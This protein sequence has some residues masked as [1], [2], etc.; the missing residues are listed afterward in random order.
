V[1]GQGEFNCA[2]LARRIDLAGRVTMVLKPGKPPRLRLIGIDRFGLV[3]ASAGMRDMVDAAPQRPA[4]PGIY[5]IKRQGR[6]DGNGRVQPRRRLP[7]LEADGGDRLAGTAGFR[8]RHPPAVTGD[9]VTA[10]D[11][12][13]RL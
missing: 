5:E 7:G 10:L 8:H 11:K 2:F 3:A 9:D 4:V 12:A 13:R 6:M 1:E